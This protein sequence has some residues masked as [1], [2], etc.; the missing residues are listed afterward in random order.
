MKGDAATIEAQILRE[1][2]GPIGTYFNCAVV[3]VQSFDRLKA[4]TKDNLE[5]EMDWLAN[6]LQTAVPKFLEGA[7]KLEALDL[8]AARIDTAD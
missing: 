6:G 7:Q 3:S 4:S 8:L 5:K 1:E 2:D